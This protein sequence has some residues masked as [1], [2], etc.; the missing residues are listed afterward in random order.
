MSRRLSRYG[1]WALVTGA[2]DGIGRAMVQALAQDGFRIVLVARR[3]SELE[4][5]AAELPTETRVVAVDLSRPEGPVTVAEAVSGLDIGLLVLAAG[6]G[7]SGP[8]VASSRAVE[9]EMID[10]N[11]RSMVDLAHRLLPGLV[12]RARGGIVVMSSLVA[13][14]GVPRAATYAATKAF[15]QS[16]A[17]GLALELAPAGVDVLASAP[18]LVG[19]GFG[20]RA[21]MRMN[22]AMRPEAAAR[23]TL[24]GLGRV[25]TVRP[26]LMSML[27]ELSLSLLPRWVRARIIGQVMYGMTRHQVP[28]I[29][30]PSA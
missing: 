17:E 4:A 22:G 5:I 6:F 15:V 30:A 3:K 18:G 2:S 8:F 19:S 10:V 23:G 1:P 27:I 25:G 29:S 13:F 7:T 24:F 9:L 20:A 21:D 16:W 11:C 12:R 28:H 26:G 14:Q